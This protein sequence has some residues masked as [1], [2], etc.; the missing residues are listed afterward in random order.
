MPPAFNLSQDQTLQFDLC[1]ISNSLDSGYP[2]PL[3]GQE[4]PTAEGFPSTALA[5]C[6]HQCLET[7]RPAETSP[8]PQRLSTHTYRLRIVKERAVAPSGRLHETRKRPGPL[9]CRRNG[10]VSKRKG[11]CEKAQLQRDEIIWPRTRNHKPEHAIRSRCLAAA[12][13]SR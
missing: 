2:H 4:Q 1:K 13:G 5:S 7:P 3:T 10:A 6:E 8:R 12:T 9:S 11:P